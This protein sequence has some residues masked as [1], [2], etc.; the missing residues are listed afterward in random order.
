MIN[1]IKS[2]QIAQLMGSS[3]YKERFIAEYIQLKQRYEKLKVF[4]T[5]IEAARRTEHFHDCRKVAMPI[6]DCPDHLLKEQQTAMGEYLHLLEVRAVIEDI[7]LQD[8]IMYL[9]DRARPCTFYGEQAEGHD[10]SV[11][12][13]DENHK[14]CCQKDGVPPCEEGLYEMVGDELPDGVMPLDFTLKTF[15]H[16][17]AYCAGDDGACS[18]CPCETVIKPAACGGMESAIKSAFYHLKRYAESK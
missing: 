18:G 15:E 14:P 2:E 4:N 17:D 6:H 10:Q 11:R 3:S 9:A 8:V 16:C 1:R 13:E 7:D 12:E 5:K